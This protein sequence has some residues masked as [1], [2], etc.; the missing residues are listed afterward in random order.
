MESQF[1]LALN[2]HRSVRVKSMWELSFKD[3]LIELL[4]VEVPLE[5]AV[6]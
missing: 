6:D 4:H 5:E 3:I 2:K 1:E